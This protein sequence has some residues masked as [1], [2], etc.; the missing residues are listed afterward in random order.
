M[1]GVSLHDVTPE[2]QVILGSLSYNKSRVDPLVVPIVQSSTY[3]LKSVQNYHD[4]MNKSGGFYSRYGSLTNENA[5]VYTRH[6]RF[7][8]ISENAF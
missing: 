4:I 3:R 8:L 6:K 5:G 7:L 2:T 1:L